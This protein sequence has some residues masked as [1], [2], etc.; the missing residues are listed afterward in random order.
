MADK[1]DLTKVNAEI[2]AGAKPKAH[3]ETHEQN[4]ALIEAKKQAEIKKGVDL[5]KTHG[6]NE[7]NTAVVV[8]KTQAEIKK[9]VEL[10]KTEVKPKE[11]LSEAAKANFLEDQK[12]KSKK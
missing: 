9:G 5:K 10:S 12:D 11:G 8:A 3:V 6:P 1:P 2:A 4:A 7:T